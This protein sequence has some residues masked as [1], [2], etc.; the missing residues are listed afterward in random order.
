MTKR[1]ELEKTA[2]YQ[3]RLTEH[4]RALHRIPELGCEERETQAYLREHLA[5]LAPDDLRAFA[6]TGLRAVFRGRGEGRTLAFRADMDALPI[7]ER[8]GCAFASAHPASPAQ[9]SASAQPSS[10]AVRDLRIALPP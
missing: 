8:S 3:D 1:L 10:P 2:A 5:A 4:R 9:V 6:D 7:E